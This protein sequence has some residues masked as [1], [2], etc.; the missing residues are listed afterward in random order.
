M[1][2]SPVTSSGTYFGASDVVNASDYE[3]MLTLGTAST[4]SNIALASGSASLGVW[5]SL[6][7]SPSYKFSCSDRRGGTRPITITIRHKVDTGVSGST[8]QTLT[9]TSNAV[10]PTFSG[11]GGTLT[12]NRGGVNGYLGTYI[13]A[14]T[15][16]GNGQF[17]SYKGATLDSRTGFTFNLDGLSESEYELQYTAGTISPSNAMTIGGNAYLFF[18]PLNFMREIAEDRDNSGARFEALTGCPAGTGIMNIVIRHK[19]DNAKIASV[20]K[21]FQT[22]T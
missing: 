2:T 14:T 22:I 9:Q 15:S 18:V 8:T 6:D 12:L 16:A 11:I 19:L 13:D 20:T 17:R 5:I 10:T 4:N 1:G 21:T 3:V 7:S